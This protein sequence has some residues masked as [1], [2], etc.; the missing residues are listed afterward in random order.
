MDWIIQTL[1]W[2]PG[3][4]I[5]LTFHEF[6]HGKAADYLG[7]S[8]PYNQ[9][10]LTLN[11]L[12][13]IDW[14]GFIMLLIF[15]FGWAKPVLV[16]PHNFRNVSI[17][18]GMMLVSIAGPAM[19]IFVALVGMLLTRIL[20]PFYQVETVSMFIQLLE[21]LILINLILAVFNLIP[22]PPLDGSKIL[23]GFLS[24]AGA[25]TLYSLEQ[26]G[27]LIL[28]LLIFTG[29]VGAIIWPIVEF[30]YSILYFIVF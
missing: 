8:T 22:L 7:D 18:K 15:K 19:N 27:P 24:D 25:N 4:L 5:G 12:P 10:R 29:A 14:V 20:L 13:H 23:A 26:Y 6:A 1:F 17:K 28:L 11:P 30:L 16:N 21:P 9:G 3:I 2:L